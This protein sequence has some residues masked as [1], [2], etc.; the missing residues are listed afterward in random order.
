MLQL[1]DC[2]CGEKR[3]FSGLVYLEDA[4]TGP[5]TKLS[6][7]ALD[8]LDQC[9]ERSNIVIATT[10]WDDD[11]N[12]EPLEKRHKEL[13]EQWR[14][15]VDRGVSVLRLSAPNKTSRDVFHTSWDIVKLL[16]AKHDGKTT[17][18][19]RAVWKGREQKVEDKFL[20]DPRET[21]FV[22]P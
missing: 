2:R 4:S 12:M 20:A 11:A 17:T 18:D 3:K 14:A 15:F 21:D 9:V 10:G 7:H 1:V 16:S 6:R 8:L 13:I 22:I 19:K 5:P